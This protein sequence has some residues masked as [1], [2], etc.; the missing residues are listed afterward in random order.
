MADLDAGIVITVSVVIVTIAGF[1]WGLREKLARLE[2]A[3]LAEHTALLET[4]KR[5]AEESARRHREMH[6]RISEEAKEHRDAHQRLID[7]IADLTVEIFR[8]PKNERPS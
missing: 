2:Q 7:K 4:M 1:F 5:M 6:E 3:N 8:G